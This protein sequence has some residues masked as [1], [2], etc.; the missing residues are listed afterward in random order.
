MTLPG[1]S[2]YSHE[3]K[4]A[5]EQRLLELTRDVQD[6]WE[7][8]NGLVDFLQGQSAF[9]VERLVDISGFEEEEAQV[10]AWDQS[11]GGLARFMST[12]HND[13][14]LTVVSAIDRTA[15]QFFE[16]D[17]D[18]ERAP[19]DPGLRSFYVAFGNRMVNGRFR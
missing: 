11:W 8:V 9:L 10:T 13:P 15:E 17:L 1:L 2:I 14:T 12:Q 5:Y 3:R 4:E 19:L 16:M 6:S 7:R 18:H